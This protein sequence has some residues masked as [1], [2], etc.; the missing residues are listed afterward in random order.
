MTSQPSPLRLPPEIAAGYPFNPQR[1]ATGGEW[2]SVA[3]AGDTAAPALL[4]VHGWPA[5]GWLWR[6]V[7]PEAAGKFRVI[8]PDMVGFGLSAKPPLSSH[9]SLER[10]TANL[11]ELIGGLGVGRLTLVL[12]GSGGPIGLGWAAR[13]P[14][15]V[16]RVVLVNTWLTPL[17]P[18]SWLMRLPGIEGRLRRLSGGMM[19]ESAMLGYLAPLR[20]HG[21]RQSLREFERM[22]RSPETERTLAQIAN[23]LK[24]LRAPVEI[25]WGKQDR[26]L[27]GPVPPYMLRDAFPNASEPRWVAE[28]GHLVPEDAPEALLEV[29]MAP[30]RPRPTKAGPLLRVL[31]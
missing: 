18:A 13:H 15:Q 14:E 24:E 21:A 25:V 29:L 16:H 6:K 20:E 11:E 26:L 8:V 17:P 7:I 2:M 28:A 1:V 19:H 30:F 22:M 12:H 3:E 10:H 31:G 5:W 23:R 4:L 9:H 27:P